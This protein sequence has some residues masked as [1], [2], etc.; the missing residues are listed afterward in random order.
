MYLIDLRTELVL[1][2]L[3]L[4]TLRKEIK[5]VIVGEVGSEWRLTLRDD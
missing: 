4:K 1:V 3:S 2:I 5:A